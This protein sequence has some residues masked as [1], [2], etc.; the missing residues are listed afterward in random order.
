MPDKGR[1]LKEF[2]DL[3]E[4]FDRREIEKEV[5]EFNL[6]NG[7]ILK[8]EIKVEETQPYPLRLIKPG[9]S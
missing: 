8:L 6:K 5:V 4:K 3:I 9:P 7:R 2:L 1:L